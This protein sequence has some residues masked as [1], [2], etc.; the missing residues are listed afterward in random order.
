MPRA[1]ARRARHRLHPNLSTV[2]EAVPGPRGAG[3][4]GR[5]PLVPTAP[6]SR[7]G[8]ADDFALRTYREVQARHA[9]DSIEI[10]R[11]PAPDIVIGD[12][13][14]VLYGGSEDQTGVLNGVAWDAARS[15]FMP[16]APHLIISLGRAPRWRDGTRSELVRLSRFQVRQSVRHLVFST[17]GAAG[18]EIATALRR[19]TDRPF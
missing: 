8:F 1:C 13:P 2:T 4:D 15:I 6:V 12:V 19:G 3:C 18:V 11:S 14:D 9:D 16:L 17:D 10:L 5:S 7:T